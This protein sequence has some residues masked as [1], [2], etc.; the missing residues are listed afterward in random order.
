MK[1]TDPLLLA[2]ILDAINE[3]VET[4]PIEHE[5]FYADKMIR[6][7]VLRH[8]QIIGEAVNRLSSDLKTQHTHL[9]WRAI[10]GMRHAIV[11]DYFEV[12]WEEVY[13]T[14]IRDI[15]PLR[16]QI[17]NILMTIASD[18]VNGDKHEDAGS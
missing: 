1:R 11:H 4:T 5:I 2:D 8:I 17:S 18:P 6:S 16:Q 3:V 12:D 13:T 15:P 10:T 9:P 7:H 14:A